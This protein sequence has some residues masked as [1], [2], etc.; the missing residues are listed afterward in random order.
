MQSPTGDGAR[1]HATGGE[2]IPS[3][4]TSLRLGL[5]VR[6]VFS[7]ANGSRRL[8]FAFDPLVGDP[9]FNNLS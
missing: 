6:A 2:S 5:P 8:P 1:F 9:V 7:D 4:R 3:V